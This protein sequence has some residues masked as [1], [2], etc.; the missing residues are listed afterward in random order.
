MGAKK[1]VLESLKELVNRTINLS[2][3]GYDVFEW[4]IIKYALAVLEVL[5]KNV[6]LSKYKGMDILTLGEKIFI[7]IPELH[8]VDEILNLYNKIIK[9]IVEEFGEASFMIES[10]EFIFTKLSR[11]R[12]LEELIE[13]GRL[14][15]VD[16]SPYLYSDDS[17][18]FIETLKSLGNNTIII[19]VGAAHLPQIYDFL[20]E[21]KTGRPS[22]KSTK[23]H[24]KSKPP[25]L[26]SE[27]QSTAETDNYCRICGKSIPPGH[28]ICEECK[29]LLAGEHPK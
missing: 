19:K 25:K 22:K 6:P 26:P 3:S 29:A 4:Y 15:V 16:I 7:I 8:I 13:S 9:N 10:K 18:E 1:E 11:L 27:K 24:A 2:Q 12:G 20:E 28:V 5:E 23:Q 17:G 14:E 21:Y